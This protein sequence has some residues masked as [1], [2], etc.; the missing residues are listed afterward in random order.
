MINAKIGAIGEND[1]LLIFKAV[2]VEVFPVENSMEAAEKIAELAKAE[3]GIIFITESIAED[4][5]DVIAEYSSRMLPSI[6]VV[7]GLRERNNYALKRLRE[8]IIKAVGA[9]VMNEK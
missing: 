2:G 3:Y 5:D 7:P 4:I 9:D 1:V 8:S 6:V